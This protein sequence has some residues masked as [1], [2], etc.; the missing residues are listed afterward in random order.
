MDNKLILYN[1][2]E[3][4]QINIE[5]T[6]IAVDTQTIHDTTKDDQ[7]FENNKFLNQ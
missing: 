6:H 1:K 4:K 2:M 3:Q 7:P 5:K